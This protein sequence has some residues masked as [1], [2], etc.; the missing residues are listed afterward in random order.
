MVI[1][2]Q[3]PFGE[4]AEQPYCEAC[5]KTRITGDIFVPP[6]PTTTSPS[7]LADDTTQKPSP[8]PD[9][10]AISDT[11]TTPM[12]TAD[13]VDADPITQLETSMDDLTLDGAW[14]STTKEAAKVEFTKPEPSPQST[15]VG[16]PQL[17]AT[18][19]PVPVP[20][21]A[22][23]GRAYGRAQARHSNNSSP[24]TSPLS[25]SHEWLLR[26]SSYSA[27]RAAG[28]VDG[29]HAAAHIRSSSLSSHPTSSLQTSPHTSRPTSP[30]P[31]FEAALLSPNAT[32]EFALSR[33]SSRA[34]SVSGWEPRSAGLLSRA[35]SNA[36][37]NN[38]YGR[39]TPIANRFSRLGGT[40][41]CYKCNEPLYMFEEVPGPRAT[42][43]HRRCLVCKLCK[44]ELDSMALM[45]DD[46]DGPYCR[47]CFT[48][49]GRRITMV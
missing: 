2:P 4:I 34:S 47:L 45:R 13:T 37:S 15:P 14:H 40:N 26:G 20:T 24:S 1:G 35:Q 32:S 18:S 16:S 9:T 19:S 48:K 28:V 29:A 33:S 49:K 36:T 17:T 30:R 8:S 46:T 38:V 31:A 11:L 44:K 42:K 6:S 22:V 10:T 12:M 5:L 7:T 23:I 39:S 41:R 3:T 27:T 25:S 43:W 21:N